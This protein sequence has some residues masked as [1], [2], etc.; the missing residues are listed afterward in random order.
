M[1]SD[2]PCMMAVRRRFPTSPPLDIRASVEN[3]FHAGLAKA[4]VPGISIGVAVGSRGITNLLPIVVC[5]LD[6]LKKSGCR[7]FVVPAMGAHGGATAE[8]QLGVLAGYGITEQTIGTPIKAS[9]DVELVGHTPDGLDVFMSAEAL[10]ADGVI[11]VNRIKPH[12]FPGRIG[13]GILKMIVVGLGKKR[14]A[15][16]FHAM[17]SRIG[18]ENVIRSAAD[19][20]LGSSLIIGGLA[21]VEDQLHQTALIEFLPRERVVNR[22]EELLVRAKELMPSLPF[23]DI[24]LLIVDQIG[25]NISGVGM[26]PNII[27]RDVQGY[28][29]SL[30]TQDARNPI[31]RRI[32]VRDLTPETHGNA[33]GIGLADVT[34]SRLVRGVDYRVTYI[35]ALTS[36]TPQ[37]AKIPIHFESDREAIEQV[38]TSLAL[39]VNR[40]P[41][42]VRIANTLLLE[43]VEVSH[44]Y[45]DLL[46]NRSDLCP[47]GQWEKMQF[48][49]AGDLSSVAH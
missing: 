28:S 49:Q 20:L 43:N 31:I 29:S 42:I 7:P 38:L 15:Q 45:R 5:L 1:D 14:G 25:K 10:H 23:D 22:E 6:Q 19:V 3:A 24:D 9:M 4:I 30:Q 44:A 41:K 37:T 21:I 36:L 27:G 35:N 17:A 40:D 39:P 26:D 16:A 8:G 13:S 11:A 47:I 34:T 12:N 32:F 48:N 33:I 2:V 46:A 18:H